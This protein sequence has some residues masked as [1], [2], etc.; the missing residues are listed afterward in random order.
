MSAY[1]VEKTA[2]DKLVR[3]LLDRGKIEPADATPIGRLLLNECIASVSFRYP[4]ESVASLPGV[5]AENELWA[6]KGTEVYSYSD[7]GDVSAQE[8]EYAVSEY[9][10]Q[11]CEH[12]GYEQSLAHRL[13]LILEGREPT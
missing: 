5:I 12:P 3:G 13:I 11:S 8:L 4:N 6:T 10:Y 9:D 1:I 7:P 2:I